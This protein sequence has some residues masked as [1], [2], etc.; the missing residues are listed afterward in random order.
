MTNF[1]SKRVALLKNKKD[2]ADIYCVTL[3]EL[4]AHRNAFI[5]NIYNSLSKCVGRYRPIS[6]YLHIQYI[7]H[8]VK[9]KQSHYRPGQALRVPAV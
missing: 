8:Y 5:Q 4:Q 2:C 9:V 7:R 3:I 6:K 1:S